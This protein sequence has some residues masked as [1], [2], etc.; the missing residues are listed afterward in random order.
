MPKTKPFSENLLRYEKWFAEN[1]RLYE[2]EI[3]TLK[4]FIPAE[5]L[6]LEVGVGSG[7]FSK[8]LGVAFGIDPCPEMLALAQKRGIKIMAGVAEA[9]PCKS[10][11]FDY[12][13]MVTVV[14]FFDDPCKAF[15]EAKRVLVPGGRLIVAY[16]DRLSPLGQE[17][18]EHQNESTFYQEAHFFSSPELQAMMLVSG[19]KQFSFRQVVP[20][21][22]DGGEAFTVLPGY[23]EGGFVVVE[24]R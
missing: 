18:L 14:C 12:I 19:F 9:L 11:K 13:L 5:G 10:L 20:T 2:A 21:G 16:V 4:E 15:Q 22:A 17:Y 6:G 1:A 7:L 24:A 3:A 23:G 8:P